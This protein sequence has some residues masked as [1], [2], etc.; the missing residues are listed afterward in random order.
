MQP[1]GTHR[2]SIEHICGAVP[3][4][5]HFPAHFLDGWVSEAG[6]EPESELNRLSASRSEK[7][8]VDV[9]GIEPV[10]PACKVNPGKTIFVVS[11]SLLLRGDARF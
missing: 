1:T 2:T 5:A 9:T 4:P 7:N 6:I 10:P 8:L 11:F 3:I